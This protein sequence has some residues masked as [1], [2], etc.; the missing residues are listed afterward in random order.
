MSLFYVS[1]QCTHA[2]TIGLTAFQM[3]KRTEEVVVGSLISI[4]IVNEALEGLEVSTGISEGLARVIVVYCL[5]ACSLSGIIE[6]FK[7]GWFISLTCIEF[8]TLAIPRTIIIL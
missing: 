5:P 7:E 2:D 6:I 1:K 4:H 3:N 8:H